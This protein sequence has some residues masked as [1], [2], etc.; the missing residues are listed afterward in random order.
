MSIS[1]SK[2][3]K[4]IYID[5]SGSNIPTTYGSGATSLKATGL[6]GLGYRAYK[7]LNSTTAR[8]AISFTDADASTPD[9]STTTN[10]SQ[11]FIAASTVEMKDF[12]HVYDK[13]YIRSD[14]GSAITTGIIAIEFW[15]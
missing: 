7:V 15:G 4:T 11:D 13:L 14:S 12:F 9:S 1:T 2:R 3:L 8:I 6:G 10:E 5:A